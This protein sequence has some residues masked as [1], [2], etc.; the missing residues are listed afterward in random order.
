VTL[1]IT[2]DGLEAIKNEGVITVGGTLEG[3]HIDEASPVGVP[4]DP[5]IHEGTCLLNNGIFNIE[6]GGKLDLIHGQFHT[7]DWTVTLST[8]NV[9]G[10]EFKCRGIS[11]LPNGEFNLNG[12]TLQTTGNTGVQNSW[13]SVQNMG[14]FTI[15][16]TSTI[17]LVVSRF[18][19][20]GGSFNVETGA[21]LNMPRWMPILN[22]GDFTVIGDLTGNASLH[23]GD[24][25]GDANIGTTIIKSGATANFS[26]ITNGQGTITNEGSL[27]CVGQIS[28]HDEIII[29][30]N[31]SY[32][33]HPYISSKSNSP[34]I[35]TIP[36][37]TLIGTSNNFI[38]DMITQ[39]NSIINIPDNFIFTITGYFTNQS[40]LSTTFLRST[41]NSTVIVEGKFTNQKTEIGTVEEPKGFHPPIVISSSNNFKVNTFI[42]EGVFT[43]LSDASNT[44]SLIIEATASNSDTLKVYRH[45]DKSNGAVG[46]IGSWQLVSSPLVAETT[47]IFTGHFLNEYDAGLG[48]FDAISATDNILNPGQGYIAKLDFADTDGDGVADKQEIIFSNSKFNDQNISLTLGTTADEG[49]GLSNTYFDLPVGFHLVG[50]PYPSNLD[51]ETVYADVT[52]SANVTNKLYYYV[53]DGNGVPADPKNPIA[54]NGKNGW[55]VYTV[56]DGGGD[57]IIAMAQGFGVVLTGNTAGNF[58]IPRSATT[59]D[60]GDGFHKKQSIDNNSFKLVAI[61]NNTI[62]DIKFKF[63][64]SAT[65]DY[66]DEFDAYKLKSFGDSPTP[67]FV[68]ADGRKLA[69]CEM[70]LSESVELGFSK[71]TS[72]EV[73]FSVADVQDFTE[74]LLEDKETGIYT[75]LIKDTYTFTY[76]DDEKEQGR[77]S[78]YF[79]QEALSEIEELNNLNVY[80]SDN[81]LYIKSA[82]NLNDVN[83]SIYNVSGQQVLSNNFDTLVNEEIN[84]G[85]QGVYIL[86]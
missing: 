23:N 7:I 59:F 72:A 40:D 8:V 42:N 32:E 86:K 51:W 55:K 2:G 44:A 30:N 63:N 5:P 48:D 80:S 35:E 57:E 29:E 49:G 74:I 81:T 62:D 58:T 20:Q 11:L 60:K 46:D 84:T 4:R 36:T 61:S 33:A 21:K 78:L 14:T 28:N 54:H 85:L 31:G 56:G 43:M 10:G 12:G 75:D 71:K 39:D 73:I 16:G 22:Y 37:L 9:N 13:R 82:K 45:V 79:K 26:S 65:N 25:W 19:N 15:T 66:D 83:V 41:N 50:N 69:I 67:Y 27:V 3:T 70:P 24:K 76:S 38:G 64:E 1:T 6:S 53:D 47:E 17:D 18:R 34:T 52:N 77:F 68:S